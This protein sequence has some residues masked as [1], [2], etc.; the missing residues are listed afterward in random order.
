MATAGSPPES[1]PFDAVV[2]DPLA[3]SQLWLVPAPSLRSELTASQYVARV[4]D[5]SLQAL[6]NFCIDA[7]RCIRHRGDVGEADMVRCI[8]T[9]RTSEPV[10]LQ[11][12]NILKT[13]LLPG[14]PQYI[15]PGSA[16]LP[17]PVGLN[18]R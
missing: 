14:R 6:F 16:R 5:Q 10:P 13:Y 17:M 1:P 12:H 9:Q 11:V 2:S 8:R 18:L 7:D 3:L 4:G 15:Q